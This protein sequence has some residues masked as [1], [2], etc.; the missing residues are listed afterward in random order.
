MTAHVD[1][2][3]GVVDDRPRVVV[4]PRPLGQAQRDHALAQHVFHRLPEAEIDAE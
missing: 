4:Q 2:Q 1:Q 3:R